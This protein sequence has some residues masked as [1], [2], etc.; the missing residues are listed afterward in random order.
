MSCNVYLNILLYLNICIYRWCER[1]ILYPKDPFVVYPGYRWFKKRI[2]NSLNVI[3]ASFDLFNYLN[4]SFFIFRKCRRMMNNKPANPL[5]NTTAVSNENPAF[6]NLGTH[7]DDQLSNDSGC[8]DIA[9]EENGDGV[10]NIIPLQTFNDTLCTLD[11]A[12]YNHIAIGH[13]G[14]ISTD[15][16]YAH[17]PNTTAARYD[18]TYSHLPSDHPGQSAEDR[19]DST[20]NHLNETC[21]TKS[22]PRNNR[23]ALDIN[24]DADNN[25]SYPDAG[26]KP[27]AEYEDNTY[28]HLGET[29]NASPV[30]RNGQQSDSTYNAIGLNVHTQDKNKTKASP[31]SYTAV[32]PLPHFKTAES[33]SEDRPHEYLVLE[34]NNDNVA[35][36]G[37]KPSKPTPYDY[38]IVN[39]QRPDDES[40]KPSEDGPHE[41]FVLEKLK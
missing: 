39:N 17:I 12:T 37:D 14:E 23:T 27:L 32:N 19:S 25:Y 33:Q 2:V 10:Y 38:A 5:D 8:P 31:Y 1:T 9:I 22:R 18:N 16:M 4:G 15:N 3:D 26:S 36:S 11:D 29:L 13:S 30:I 35:K 41:Y 28:N 21:N 34:P 20:Y 7:N 24:T 6:A 40:E